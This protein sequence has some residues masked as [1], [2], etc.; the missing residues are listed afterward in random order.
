MTPPWVSSLWGSTG[1]PLGE[2]PRDHVTFL[3]EIPSINTLR[4]V[5][6][7]YFRTLPSSYQKILMPDPTI[8]CRPTTYFSL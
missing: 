8:N 7:L 1:V 4:W 6:L 2:I 3:Q 5:L